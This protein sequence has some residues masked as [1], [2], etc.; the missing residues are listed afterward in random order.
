MDNNTPTWILRGY[1]TH[2]PQVN[3]PLGPLMTPLW[4][5][6]N[7]SYH[8]SVLTTYIII[9]PTSPLHYLGNNLGKR[10]SILGN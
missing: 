3:N 6:H 1:V 2:Q 9:P 7:Q 8:G 5:N 10:I 4:M